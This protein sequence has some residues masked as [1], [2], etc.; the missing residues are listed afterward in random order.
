MTS[1][2]ANHEVCIHQ[3]TLMQ[4]DFAESVRCLAR[5]GVGKTAIWHEKLDGLSIANA[6]Q[7]LRDEGVRATSF[8]VALLS[9]HEKNSADLVLRQIEQAAELGAETIVVISG[10]LPPGSRDITSAR[11]AA[12]ERLAQMLEPA[13]A[14]GLQIGLEPLHP[15]VCGYRSLWSTLDEAAVVLNKIDAG[16]R[17]GLVLD[18]YALWWDETLLVQIGRHRDRIISFHASDWLAETKDLRLDRGIPGDGVIDIAETYAALCAGGS[19][20]DIEVEIL[21][22]T[23][24]Q[25]DPDELVET[26]LSRVEQITGLQPGEEIAC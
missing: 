6:R 16:A 17:A 1:T 3:A 21:S 18:T 12:A 11:A 5:H 24:W 20:P 22:K 15:M 10:G 13:H 4:C 26:I 9:P 14:S 2:P 19:A 8:C 25:A 7:T 23:L